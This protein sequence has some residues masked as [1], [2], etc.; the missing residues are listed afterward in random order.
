MSLNRLGP[1]ARVC[2][3]ARRSNRLLTRVGHLLRLPLASKAAK[4][5]S[6]CATLL[7]A[8]I[9]ASAA[10]DTTTATV[11]A[12]NCTGTNGATPCAN[13]R[14]EIATLAQLRRLSERSQDWSSA[15][16][17]VLT[18]DIDAS[19]TST[20]NVGDHDNNVATGPVP[21][22]FSPVGSETNPFQG[23][24]DGAGFAISNLTINRPANDNI[25]LFGYIS[26]AD[27]TDLGVA[28]ASI[29]GDEYVGGLVGYAT[30][31]ST[32][33]ASY[34][35]G[36]VTGS[37]NFSYVG[38]LVG[39]ADNSSI[40]AS[41]ATGAV[42]GSGFFVGGLVGI[43]FNGSTIT[44]SYATGAVTGSRSYV[45]GLVGYLRDNSSITASYATGAVTGSVSYVGGLVGYALNSSTITASYATGAVTGSG[46]FSYVGGLV[47]IADN[48]SITASYA[49]GAVTG[50]QL[51]GGLVG[52][53]SSSSS[54][55][56][57]YW[58]TDASPQLPGVGDASGVTGAPTGLSS[59]EMLQ[60]SSFTG[61]D[62]VTDPPGAPVND[63]PWVI[64]DGK[65]QPY[66]YWQDDDGDG[67]AAYLDTDD[68]GDS[69][70]DANDAFPLNAAASVDID[71]DGLPDDWNTGCDATCQS[72]SGLTLDSDDDGDGVDDNL[73]IAPLD[74]AVGALP[75][76][77]PDNPGT[78]GNPYLIS[79]LAHLEG[80]STAQGYW[81]SGVHLKLTADIDASDTAN[82]NVGD[83][84][85]NV[86]TDPVPMGFS[87]VGSNTNSFQGSFDGA[88]FAISNLTINRPAN[89]DIGLFGATA[90][91]VISDVGVTNASITGDEY[92]GGLVGYATSSSTIT[93]SYATGAVTGSGNFV[94]G[95]VGLTSTSSTITASYATG[96]VTGSGSYVGGLVGYAFNGSTITAS[97]ATGAVTGSVS[98]VG[99]LVGYLRDN[100]SITASY[101]TGAVT[102]SQLVGGLYVGNVGG[103]V[104]IA[105]NSSITA[106][107]ATGAVTGS[108]LVGGLVGVAS[109]SSIT[110][111]YWDTDA[112]PQLPGVGDA[113][114]VTGAPT[115]LSS[116]EMLQQSSFTGFD[117]VTDPPGD[118]VSDT[119]WVMIDGSTRPYLYWQDDDGDGDAAYLD[120]FPLNAAASVDT[121]GDGLPDDWN[122]G[123]DATCQSASG[124]TLDN[125]D[126]EDGVD[127][128]LDVYPLD[129]TLSTFPTESPGDPGTEGN[130]YLIGTLTELEGLSRVQTYWASGVHLKLTADIDASDTST[131]NVGDHDNNV[132][133][134]PVPMGFSPVGSETNPFQG[135]FDGA[136]FAISNLTV[137]RPGTGRVGLFGTTN[138]AVIE[139][140]GL[141]DVAIE[142]AGSVGGLVGYESSGTAI[143]NSYASGS[144][145]G[146]NNWVG[147]LVGYANSTSIAGSYAAAAVSS[148]GNSVGGLVGYAL[149]VDVTGSHA[150]GTA[151]GAENVGGLVGYARQ[152]STIANSYA[153]GNVSG[154]LR[155]GGLVGYERGSSI[156]ASYATGA[157]EGDSDVGGL[158]GYADGSSSINESYALGDV[159]GDL[160]AGG[161]VG[162]LRDNSSITA[163]Y[164][165]GA[166]GGKENGA[167]NIAAGGLVGA[168]GQSS[169]TA[170]YATGTVGGDSNVGG[171]VG[172]AF[173]SSSITASYAAGAVTGTTNVGG[174]LGNGITNSS[175][176]AS[177]W[178]T[179]ASMQSQGVGS[180]DGT[181]TGTP[182]VLTSTAMLAQ[183]SFV[184]FNFVTDPPGAPVND[185]PWVII[186]GKT[187]PYLY[188]QDD[189]GDGD[190]AYLD[191]DDDGDG[192]DDENDR[193][194]LVSLTVNAGTANEETLPD[195]NGNGAPDAVGANC[196]EA[197]IITAGMALDQ[198]P[199]AVDV[200]AATLA[201]TSATVVLEGADADVDALTYSV[202]SGP[203]NGT[204]SDPNNGDAAV[205]T[206]AITGQT[207][208]Y[209]PT[210][211][212]TG[213]D[214]FTYTVNDGVSDSTTRTATITVFDAVRTQAQQIGA[215][216]DGE[217]AGDYSGY[218]VSLSSDGQTVA[219]GAYLN[220]GNGTDSG[221]VRVYG[222]DGSTWNQRGA[223]I[224]GEAASDNSGWSVSLSS[225]GQ[226]VAIGA[227]LNDGNGT[228]SGHVRVYGYD[229]STW[230]QRG[231]DI[232]GEDAGDY[233]GYS[234]S[235]SSDGQTVA[236]GATGNDANGTDSGHVRVYGYDGSTW[237]QRGAD[238]D[239]EAVDDQSGYSV[240]LSSDGQTVAIGAYRND[241]NGSNSGH[242]RVYGYNGSTWNQRGADIDGEA[243]EDRSGF[244]VS[245]SSDGQ[246]V[247]I[248]AYRNDGNGSN[249][250][251]VRVY[252]W[253][254]SGWIKL[255]ANIDGEAASDYSGG[256]VSLSSD[257]QTV[258]IGA[259]LNDGNGSNSGHVRVYGYDGSTWTQRGAD[260]D[261]EAAE[262]RSGFSVSLSSD[263]QTVAIGA[264]RND[265]NGSNSGHVRVY[266]LKTF[267]PAISGTPNRTA[268][269]GV[270]YQAFDDPVT[271]LDPTE[272]L[273]V[274]DPDAADTLTFSATAGG[275]ALPAWLAVDA[276]TG[277]LSGT[278]AA[279][280]VGVVTSIVLTVSD[281][282]LSDDLPA[283]DLTVL[284]DTDGDGDPD[285]CGT[286]CV[287]SGFT[288]DADDDNDGVA[289]GEDTNSLD[290]NVCRDDDGDSAD[291][292]SVGTD[293]FGPLNDFDPSNDGLDTDGDGLAD[294]GDPDDDNDL[295]DDGLDD[296]P[297]NAAAS[298][299]T[300]GDNKPDDWNTGCDEVCQLASGLVLDEDDDGDGVQDVLDFAPLDDQ[301]GGLSADPDAQEPP[302]SA[303]NPY[304]IS[305]LAQLEGLS[306][307]TGYWASGVYLRLTQD[308][309]ASET[310]SWNVGDHDNNPDTTDE[311]M[312]FA[313]IGSQQQTYQGIF[314]GAG[315]SISNLY[316]NRPTAEAG[317]FGWV[318]LS[319]ISNLRLS[320]V[321]ITGGQPTGAVV[322]FSDRG[323]ITATHVS[324]R[325]E[326]VASQT[327]GLVGFDS[328][329]SL[330]QCSF[331]GDVT[332]PL[333]VGGL[334]GQSD[335]GTGTISA[336]YT[337]GTV[338]S[339]SVLAGGL[340]GASGA[341]ISDS[342]SVSAVSGSGSEIG[343][344]TGAHYG[345]ALAD[346]Y[347]AG[348][349][350]GSFPQVGGITGSLS[351]PGT[352][353]SAYWSDTAGALNGVGSDAANT[354]VVAL[355]AAGLKSQS[356]FVGFDFVTDPPGDPVSDT[357][358]V[359]IDGSTRPYLYWQDDDGDGIA[360]YL[361]SDDDGDSVN[362]ASDNYPLE[363]AVSLDTDGDGLPDDWNTGCDQ[364]CKDASGL[365][366]DNDD[367]NDG[368]ADGEDTDPLDPNAC[369]DLDGDSA[370]DCSV[371]TDGFG[372][373]NDFDPS[374]D[375]LDTDGDGLAD[376][377][378]PDDDNDLVGDSLDACPSTPNQEA[379]DTQG[380]S[381]TQKDD[382]ND[383]VNNADDSCP[384]TP[385]TESGQ[386]N[387][388]GCGPSER[389]TDG[390][391]V[392][393][394]LDAFP[395]NPNETLDSDGDGYGDNEEISEGTDPNDA[396]DQPIQSGLPIWLLYE[397][398]KP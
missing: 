22:G 220:D 370:D 5:L 9:A 74:N 285:D 27:I 196:D 80:L 52:V 324:G 224:D 283:F 340:V 116:A 79:T 369:Q 239:G 206:G 132:A 278:P 359:M 282:T 7:C 162:Y 198:A 89:D 272:L 141:V 329:G 222:Y 213:P 260:I 244:S 106:S 231:A 333:I 67:V 301:V 165:D 327:G 187:Q 384:T 148:S 243:A 29:T 113:S 358:W 50:S 100:S 159:G 51:V 303:T 323:S 19:D 143:T 111:S 248:G 332:G 152:T 199:T 318:Y 375:G 87:P 32:I 53:A 194:P 160:R 200:Y 139:N 102:G 128:G 176:T 120:D 3:S 326:G 356:S 58:D 126:D 26:G 296:F 83:H 43:A 14:I 347:F 138:S 34:A 137:N 209:T 211:N 343:G 71:G 164:A 270:A 48:S 122:T 182:T 183:S 242:V 225:D 398:S 1:S 259:Y 314:D 150:T 121:D 274:S 218:S 330:S 23:S 293:G 124:L 4:P 253:N 397:A 236:I 204:L 298:V 219:I 291:D 290:P 351:S 186:D 304:L 342:Y 300:D 173:N 103:L 217:D 97:Y 118:P 157:V 203:A 115:G 371:G 221:H 174:V 142:G 88:G 230:T 354:D 188:W 372:S 193:Y 153:Q 328:E 12:N 17:V 149:G 305:T 361:D 57:S 63:T 127:D 395:L 266:D 250:G 349:V 339:D 240:S 271:A 8:T 92:V 70:N 311:A 131:W 367:D 261:G 75:T 37:G 105:D 49:T 233:S 299:D 61:F 184:G 294:V 245:L 181:L 197:C 338:S 81:D 286:D 366:L 202:V 226:T 295:V 388:E 345:G 66:L 191:T 68:D 373:L 73:D 146:N 39:I 82:W 268:V 279:G 258:A 41:Y 205:T 237:T 281:G 368:V 95:L 44:A 98:Y 156:A 60:Q 169:I 277:A 256:S 394:N 161:L 383:D 55:T 269:A 246:T 312:G 134:D 257:G 232:D 320:D 386:V 215:D 288:A 378:D 360:A 85:N 392:N 38:G 308:I 353:A 46:N 346:S 297:L 62:F 47:G 109:S 350:A 117:F 341:Q 374:N 348:T 317:L 36:A 130:P 185:T 284:L 389:D 125:D 195:A 69:L 33:T 265:G 287:T 31:S 107:Y 212:F 104:G 396:D 56:A 310:S 123:C 355:D 252:N 6:L 235:L 177:Y 390:D 238:I 247:A 322:G 16:T 201:S 78:E 280:D 136:G 234:V 325:V 86:A 364:A 241:G 190:A 189:D 30:S 379:V 135:S 163:A 255:G 229:G 172:N 254:G 175:I 24:F 365:T 289:D 362:D 84:D 94:G 144:V 166:V 65:T 223:D 59:A 267:A 380:C 93:A 292:C 167:S 77:S 64:I 170:S 151:A 154:D 158:V 313:P 331:D 2:A 376:V 309:D 344:L 382:D 11:Y 21:M 192:V 168:M 20:W 216:I 381:E 171:L 316:I 334:L 352:I 114:G 377:G 207:L 228:D 72:A 42:T 302:G 140:I 28:N 363:A 108:Q 214:S 227:Y 155:V 18:A 15:V 25:G 119:P 208:T 336:C 179:E 319:Q 76:T 110:A 180:D 262:D 129:D 40:T 145:T 385:G 249:S 306:M 321:D 251:H 54:I 387:T 307:A 147:G 90:G 10:A 357:P 210:G 391:S 335:T 337:K 263:G 99:G 276:A 35:T 178:D 275:G 13:S 315:Y 45:G 273:T 112:S 96:A 393:D 101:A 264:Y 133:T 91:A